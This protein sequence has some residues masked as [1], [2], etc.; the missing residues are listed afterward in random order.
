MLTT[1]NGWPTCKRSLPKRVA[2]LKNGSTQF[3][4]LSVGR[5]YSFSGNVYRKTKF[6]PVSSFVTCHGATQEVGGYNCVRL[7]DGRKGSFQ[8]GTWVKVIF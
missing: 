2:F 1:Y 4:W 5:K 3:G 8:N 6:E 7:R